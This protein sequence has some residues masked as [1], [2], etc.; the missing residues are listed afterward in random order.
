[1]KSTRMRLLAAAIPA[2][3]IL[4]GCD[5][6]NEP[7]D[8]ALNDTVD[9]RRADRPGAQPGTTPPAS[10]ARSDATRTPGSDTASGNARGTSGTVAESNITPASV[11]A[12]VKAEL[13][14]E[15]SLSA[16]R[17]DVD[18]NESGKVTL[19]GEVE[20]AT[21]KRRAEELARATQGVRE[22]ENKLEV[23]PA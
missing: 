23:R 5:F 3:F 6:S 4:G 9:Q 21:A 22:V 7:A 20:S 2:A 10:A 12:A 17:I 18:S 11:T 1:M 14:K 13:M 15:P 8:T 19:S 16:M